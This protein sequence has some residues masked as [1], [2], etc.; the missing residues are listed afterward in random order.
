M[1]EEIR[2]RFGPLPPSVKLL[3]SVSSARSN[4][5]KLGI[6]EVRRQGGAVLLY[7]DAYNEQMVRKA[8]AAL[9]GRVYYSARGKSYLAIDLKNGEEPLEPVFAVLDALREARSAETQKT[10]TARGKES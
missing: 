10:E 8:V 6:Y 4:A 2:D 5:S 3:C 7:G 9:P 1:T